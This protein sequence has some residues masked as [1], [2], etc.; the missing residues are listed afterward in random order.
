MIEWAKGLEEADPHIRIASI[1]TTDT[2][3]IPE[4]VPLKFSHPFVVFGNADAVETST[5]AVIPYLV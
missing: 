1:I 3:R 2:G 4:S 5:G